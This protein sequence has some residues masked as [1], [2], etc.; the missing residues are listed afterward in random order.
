MLWSPAGLDTIIWNITDTLNIL[1]II[2]DPMPLDEAV[3]KRIAG[4][5][6]HTL[7][8]LAPEVTIDDY[9]LYTSPPAFF[10]YP[11]YRYLWYPQEEPAFVCGPEEAQA[12]ARVREQCERLQQADLLVLTAP[13]WNYSI[14]A[15]L[16]AWIDLVIAPNHI[17]RFGAQ[18]L[19]PIHKL[20]RLIIFISS[21]G[22]MLRDNA[23]ETLLKHLTAPFGFIGVKNIDVVWADGQ[24]QRLF[25]DHLERE[26]GAAAEARRLAREIVDSIQK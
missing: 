10:D 18:G 15:I 1:H 6:F 4:A 21:G 2:S 8:D 20:Q 14:P 17:Y 19:E 11:T 24:D 3:D 25:P 22:T 9:D 13:V 26:V 7:S 16:K 12:G 5:F 23:R